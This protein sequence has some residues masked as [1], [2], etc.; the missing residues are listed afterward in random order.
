MNIPCNETS[1]EAVRLILQFKVEDAVEVCVYEILCLF[2][3][4]KSIV[5]L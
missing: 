5:Q 2:S 4:G 3:L 1:I